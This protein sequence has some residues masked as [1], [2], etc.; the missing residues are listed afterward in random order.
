MFDLMIPSGEPGP[1]AGW[2]EGSD[3]IVCFAAEQ[4]SSARTLRR[5]IVVFRRDGDAYRRSDELH[6]VVL[7]DP[8]EVLA[9]LLAAGFEAERLGGYGPELPFRPDVAGFLARKPR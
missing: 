1:R 3:W 8:D 4:D 6:S 5:R 7:Y 9:D 2:R